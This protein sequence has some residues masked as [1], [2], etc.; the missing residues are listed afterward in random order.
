MIVA[1]FG[2]RAAASPASLQNA[3][4]KASQDHRPDALATVADKLDGLQPL[5]ETL[6]LPIISV[7]PPK[8]KAQQTLTQSKA[9]DA[10]RDTGSVAEAAALASAGPDARLVGPRHISDDRMATCAI[11]IGGPL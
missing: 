5:A 6:D 9:S 7:S 4:I 11:A 1:G 10:A 2:F 8:L 3:L